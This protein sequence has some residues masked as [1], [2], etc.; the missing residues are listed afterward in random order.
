M[1]TSS[2]LLSSYSFYS[3]CCGC[4]C[5]LELTVMNNLIYKNEKKTFQVYQVEREVVYHISF[6]YFYSSKIFF[7]SVFLV[8]FLIKHFSCTIFFYPIFLF[9]FINNFFFLIFFY[10][11]IIQ[12]TQHKI[13]FSCEMFSL[14]S[15][16]KSLTTLSEILIHF[17]LV[18]ITLQLSMI[19]FKVYFFLL[20]ESQMFQVKFQC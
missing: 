1:S 4:Y 8:S 5:V 15:R 2:L 3:Y 10:L 12:K 18:N 13:S 6:Y 9:A 16:K 19:F 17:F 14:K 7:F 11:F 20:I